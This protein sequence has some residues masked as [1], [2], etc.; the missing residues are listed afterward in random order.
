MQSFIVKQLLLLS[1]EA[2]VGNLLNVE[3][4][5]RESL[6]SCQN[7]KE[8]S[9][10]CYKNEVKKSNAIKVV[11]GKRKAYIVKVVMHSIYIPYNSLAY[12]QYPMIIKN[13]IVV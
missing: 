10:E 1:R 7:R 4:S 8:I 6:K 9:F 5:I 2:I 11:K 12:A 3:H 13:V